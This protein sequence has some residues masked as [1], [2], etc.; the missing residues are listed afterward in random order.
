MIIDSPIISGSLLLTGSF[1]LIG[2]TAQ[3]GSLNI[4]G[5]VN[6]IGTIT[7]TTL[8]V[9]TITSSISAITGSTKFGELSTNTH[10]FTGSVNIT[11]SLSLNSI[12]IP[13]SA[14]L[15][16]TYLQLAGGTLTGALSGTS[17]TFSGA[18]TSNGTFVAGLIGGNIQLKGSTDGFLGVNNSNTLFL[19]DW[20]TTAKGLQINL[21]TGAATFSSSVGIGAANSIGILDAYTTT[22]TGV[23]SWTNIAGTTNNFLL[24]NSANYNYGIVGVVSASGTATGDVYGLGYTASAGTSMTPVI[25]WTSGGNVGIGTSSPG[26]NLEV[27]APNSL[28]SFARFRLNSQYYANWDLLNN[29]DLAFIRGSSEYMRIT[30]GGELY[31]NLT[32]DSAA[33]LSNGGVLFR[34]NSQKYVQIA[35]GIDT[36]GLLMAFYKKNGAGITNTGSIATS[37]NN[38]LYNTTSDYRLKEDLKDFDGIEKILDIKIY[39]FAWKLD[40]TRSYGVMAHELADILPYAVYGKKD[41]IQEDG[42]IQLQQVDYSKLVPILVKSIQEQQAQIEEL[43]AQNDALQSRIE[44]LEQK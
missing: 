3:T 27:A 13:T 35:T 38:T 29:S 44:T 15:A 26:A 41:A 16:L 17:A 20:A 8:V 22:K 9:Q 28:G 2:N 7:A 31:W 34:N 32:S 23:R 19:T 4:S 11:G 5:S 25:N 10:Q 36:D 37:G 21:S 12:T 14:S 1:N 33:G 42:E 30:S 24:Q 18:V 40:N 39:D 6:T 43:K